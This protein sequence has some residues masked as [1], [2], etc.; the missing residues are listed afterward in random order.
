MAIVPRAASSFCEWYG[1]AGRSAFRQNAATQDPR[2]A[3][4]SRG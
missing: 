1:R 3:K 2:C 4:L